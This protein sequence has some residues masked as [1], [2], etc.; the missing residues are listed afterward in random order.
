[1]SGGA[2]FCHAR[3][4]DDVVRVLMVFLRFDAKNELKSKVVVYKLTSCLKQ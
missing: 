3:I 1:M 4:C 2:Y